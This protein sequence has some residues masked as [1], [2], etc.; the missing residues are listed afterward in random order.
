[1]SPS[2]ATKAAWS[3]ALSVASET[4]VMP[5][6]TDR[7]GARCERF[8]LAVPMPRDIDP[9]CNPDI[10][11]FPDII[12]KTNERAGAARSSH[13]TAM[14]PDRHHLGRPFSLG[15][16]HVQCV[17]EI[18]E[19]LTTVAEPLRVDE[20]HVIGV[21]RVWNNEMRPLRPLDPIGQIVSVG[22]RR[23]EK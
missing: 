9:A 8:V 15:V 5:I 6:S 22:I 1:M 3:A 23:I 13:Q 10:V 18:G 20:S 21:E 2:A 4:V 11:A 7:P 14:Q 17:L 16:Q 19:E 12:E